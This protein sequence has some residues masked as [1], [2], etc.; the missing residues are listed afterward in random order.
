ML[1]TSRLKLLTN[2]REKPDVEPKHRHFEV[3][4]YAFDAL[5]WAHYI[6]S[7]DT[8]PSTKGQTRIVPISDAVWPYIRRSAFRQ[9]P[10]WLKQSH[11]NAMLPLPREISAAPSD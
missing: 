6:M 11:D 8:R 4:L 2:F 1:P 5:M 3:E 9:T 7:L 10:R